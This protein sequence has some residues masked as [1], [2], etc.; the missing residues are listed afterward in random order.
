M[1]DIHFGLCLIQ[2]HSSKYWIV[3]KEQL[4]F[5]DKKLVENT[6]DEEVDKAGD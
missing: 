1:N 3:Y 5:I 4:E 6:Y 2:S